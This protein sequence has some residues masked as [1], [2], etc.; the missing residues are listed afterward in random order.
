MTGERRGHS[1]TRRPTWMTPR[2]GRGL[3]AVGG[4]GGGAEPLRQASTDLIG[5]LQRLR[6]VHGG[7]SELAQLHV[8][9]RPRVRQFLITTL[10]V[11]KRLAME[12]E[13][14]RHSGCRRLNGPYLTTRTDAAAR[15]AIA[16]LTLPS[17]RSPRSP[18]LP[19]TR[20][21]A[22]VTRDESPSA[23]D[24]PPRI[25][26]ISASTSVGAASGTT[27]PSHTCRTRSGTPMRM[28][29]PRPLSS[30]FNER[31]GSIHANGD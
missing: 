4:G 16:S 5:Q 12:A 20:R 23:G 25:S 6:A 18:R 26:S 2:R 15:C 14:P 30:A 19:T 1:P 17:A 7:D 11:S 22:S 10:G 3:R 28:A 8:Y 31:V 29:R 24:S 9:A 27:V 21:S 13:R